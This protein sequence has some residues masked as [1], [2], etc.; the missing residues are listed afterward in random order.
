[1]VADC[2]DVDPRTRLGTRRAAASAPVGITTANLVLALPTSSVG[3][4]L[5]NWQRAW[6]GVV[7]RLARVFASM[8]SY[9]PVVF[10]R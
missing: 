3:I 5:S 7:Q 10:S 1:M 4:R 8:N 2:V 9:L 6:S